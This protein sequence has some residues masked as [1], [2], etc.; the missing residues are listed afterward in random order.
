[1]TPHVYLLL[2]IFLVHNSFETHATFHEENFGRPSSIIPYQDRE[3]HKKLKAFFSLN[4]QEISSR[5]SLSLWDEEQLV[6][7]EDFNLDP[8]IGIQPNFLEV[9]EDDSDF[10]EG[11]EDEKKVEFVILINIFLKIL[12]KN[13][14]TYTIKI[15]LPKNMLVNQEIA[16]K[17]WRL[18]ASDIASRAFKLS[19]SIEEGDY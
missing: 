13:E 18:Q 3:T 4:P 6:A 5:H 10:L 1:M 17:Q 9:L 15:P 16:S 7:L 19:T 11:I 2:F 12:E 14:S 8:S